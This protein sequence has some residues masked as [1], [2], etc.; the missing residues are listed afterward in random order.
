MIGSASTRG[1]H[2]FR[3]TQ[4]APAGH[5]DPARRAAEGHSSSEPESTRP[6]SQAVT[7]QAGTDRHSAQCRGTVVGR[8]SDISVIVRRRP[9]E[10]PAAV[11][12]DGQLTP[13]AVMVTLTGL[14][15]GACFQLFEY[16]RNLSESCPRVSIR[17]RIIGTRSFKEPTSFQ[18]IRSQTWFKTVC[19]W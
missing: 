1:R 14:C 4:S 3:P 13:W 17:L 10:L 11:T 15:D 2:K 12:V 8:V 18:Q 5:H 16:T 9:G 7:A 6:D 19:G